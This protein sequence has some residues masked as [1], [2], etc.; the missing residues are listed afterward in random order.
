M[1]TA[2]SKYT[3]E[4]GQQIADMVA[5]GQSWPAIAKKIGVNRTTLWRWRDPASSNYEPDLAEA[6][7][8]ATEEAMQSALGEI[9]AIAD[10]VGESPGSAQ[11]TQVKVKARMYAFD[12]RYHRQ[13]QT[14]VV[15]DIA[16][17]KI[18]RIVTSLTE[19]LGPDRVNQIV[20]TVQRA[21]EE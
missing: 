12:K 13:F 20:A 19:E 10:Q 5:T 6:V 11:A 21:V 4:I 8:A 17:E 18:K 15:S 2:H 16:A 1:A 14:P 9:V 3:R 7:R